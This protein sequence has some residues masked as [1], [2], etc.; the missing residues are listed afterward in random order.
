MC[1]I[2]WVQIYGALEKKTHIHKTIMNTDPSAPTYRNEV[3]DDSRSYAGS[4]SKPCELS[5]A[6]LPSS[7]LELEITTQSPT[8]ST[9]S[10][11]SHQ[12]W[13]ETRRTRA[14]AEEEADRKLIEAVCAASLA[15]FKER[16]RILK[17]YDQSTDLQDLVYS[18]GN[19]EITQ[20]RNEA[21]GVKRDAMQR[22]LNS[23]SYAQEMCLKVKKATDVFEEKNA[24]RIAKISEWEENQMRV[25]QE[26]ALLLLEKRKGEAVHRRKEA[27]NRA[28]EARVRAE[29]MR[30]KAIHATKI[31]REMARRQIDHSLNAEEESR[32][33]ELEQ[34]KIRIDKTKEEAKARRELAILK[35]EAAKARADALIQKANEAMFSVPSLLGRKSDRWKAGALLSGD[36]D[37]VLLLD[38]LHF[39]CVVHIPSSLVR[40][41]VTWDQ[42]SEWP[43]TSP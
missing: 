42:D 7:L 3:D 23:K 6:V 22:I 2:K 24:E 11:S 37:T 17:D 38:N 40:S 13:E 41:G 16:E 18:A 27:E 36:E 32:L 20:K 31:V 30:E 8:S 26:T 39:V 14:Q 9:T 15:E 43:S 28:E 19:A 1:G 5:E 12:N 35:A 21:L 29:E 4:L 34:Q 10:G 33:R 25:E